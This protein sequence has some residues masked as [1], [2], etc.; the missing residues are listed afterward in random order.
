MNRNNANEN[1]IASKLK[2]IGVSA[3]AMCL[4]LSLMLTSFWGCS[5]CSDNG[6]ATPDSPA[7]GEIEIKDSYVFAEGV[8]VGGIDLSG[9]TY[10]EAVKLLDKECNNMISDFTLTVKA[11]NKSFEY[12]K[13]SFEWDT[14]TEAVLKQ[15]VSYSEEIF[16]AEKTGATAPKERTFELSFSVNPES[17]DSVCSA[18]AKEVDV[19]PKNAAIGDTD[20]HD[21]EI[22]K[23]SVGYKLDTKSLAED[24]T[25]E[26]GQLSTGK[27]ASAEIEATVKEIQPELT[28]DDIDSNIELLATFSTY[29]YNT[30]DG[31]HN[32][33]LALAACNGSVIEPGETWS[34]NACTGD[35][36]LTSLGYRPA[37]VIVGGKYQQGIGGGI[38]QAS[39][40]IYNAALLAN[41]TVV[42]RYNHYYQSSYAPAGLDA[43]IDYPNLDLKLRNDTE[44]PVYLQ[45]YMS[46]ATL[47]CKIYGWQDPSFDEIKI[48]SNI[49][50]ANRAENYYYAS[51]F[52]TYYKDGK[53]VGE[54]ELPS[55]MYHYTSPDAEPE[56]TAKPTKPAPKPTKPTPKP[57]KP[58]VIVT[59]PTEAKPTTP[60]VTEAPTV[61]DP[62]VT[63]APEA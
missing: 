11:R 14:T 27:K 22:V 24:M 2:T 31:D 39:T 55:S 36:N 59:E 58:A 19:E 10:G 47:Y 23:D 53:K 56:T 44:Y 9:I 13:D 61:T 7:I 20:N 16:E 32:M 37:T 8:T 62:P 38:C 3:L 6:G 63:D 29:S 40:T 33:A 5:S 28:Y 52:R 50:S 45:C 17:V 60:P 15:A 18:I 42:E 21:V 34:F 35:S 51:A 41:L 26:I 4:I 48:T 54:E 46:G 12:K 57:T 43:T 1:T 30:A 49:H 25:K